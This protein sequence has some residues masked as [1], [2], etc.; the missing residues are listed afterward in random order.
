MLWVC[1]QSFCLCTIPIVI[2]TQSMQTRHWIPYVWS[3]H[4]L[5]CFVCIEINFSTRFLVVLILFWLSLNVW[6]WMMIFFLKKNEKPIILLI[7]SICGSCCDFCCRDDAR[8]I[9]SYK[10]GNQLS[11]VHQILLCTLSIGDYET[12]IFLPRR[13]WLKGNYDHIR[14]IAIINP[15][16]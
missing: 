14:V 1:I 10:C 12:I 13:E 16:V 11:F 7:T 9:E 2:S 6:I 8:T 5:Y 3:N 15:H 4:F